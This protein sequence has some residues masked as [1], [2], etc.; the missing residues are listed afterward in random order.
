M[1]ARKILVVATVAVIAVFG[2]RAMSGR[3]PAAAALQT[4]TA[5][6]ARDDLAYPRH[7]E[8]L[9]SRVWLAT[10]PGM[11]EGI[12]P[13]ADLPDARFASERV[14]GPSELRGALKLIRGLDWDP[15]TSSW[16]GSGGRQVRYGQVLDLLKAA[17]PTPRDALAVVSLLTGTSTPGVPDLAAMIR[18][19]D[20]G[21]VALRL[22]PFSGDL[23]TL[24]IDQG[25]PPF[26]ERIE[27]YEGYLVRCDGEGWPGG[28]RVLTLR[29]R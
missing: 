24:L 11:T 23:G 3:D 19:E 29:A 2:W 16:S 28:W 18:R 9:R 22:R 7:A 8:L 10:A 4:H 15:A 13:F 20:N 21:L 12:A 1:A 6:H 25:R 27:S 17:L 5:I 14:V 26:R